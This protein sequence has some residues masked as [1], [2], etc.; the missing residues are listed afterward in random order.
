M[1][2]LTLLAA[3]LLCLAVSCSKLTG[4]GVALQ[5]DD[6]VVSVSDAE[7][8][9]KTVL[10]GETG[11][12][13]SS[14]D[15]IL[16]YDSADKYAVYVFRTIT[17]G[18]DNS[19]KYIF[20]KKTALEGF[21]KSKIVSAFYPADKV[22][23]SDKTSFVAEFEPVQ[24]Y[25]ANS[26]PKGAVPMTW[27]GTAGSEIEF[28]NCF[29]VVCFSFKYSSAPTT[30]VSIDTISLAGTSTKLYGRFEF[31]AGGAT[32][33]EGGSTEIKLAG[34]PAAGA[35]ETTEKYYYIAVPELTSS[36][37]KMTV[38]VTP[39]TDEEFKGTFTAACSGS[40]VN[41]IK[42]NNILMMNPFILNPVNSTFSVADWQNDGKI[43]VGQ[44]TLSETDVNLSKGS[45]KD[46]KINGVSE[47]DKIQIKVVTGN[48]SIF[49][50]AKTTDTGEDGKT[51]YYITITGT[52]AGTG[53]I[54]VNDQVTN[55][56]SYVDI[57]V[58]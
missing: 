39:T 13:F 58:N 30:A 56:G 19:K 24:T 28:E 54:F 7:Y 41:I 8:S 45:S 22:K 42:A 36:P 18:G 48:D 33:K 3:S 17:V 27:F 31:A 44:I 11:V 50:T 23:S 49:T 4:E 35:L 2:R 32:W 9:T 15:Q 55:S 20:Q 29:G 14:S 25:A 16:V 40:S 43:K 52:G 38:K 37:E 5:E 26:F 12:A 1:D 6:I 57:K 10:S 47:W 53:R 21:D 46:I 34:C 51:E